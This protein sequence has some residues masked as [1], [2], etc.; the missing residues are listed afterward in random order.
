MD[1]HSD[2]ATTPVNNIISKICVACVEDVKQLQNWYESQTKTLQDDVRRKNEQLESAQVEYTAIIDQLKKKHAELEARIVGSKNEVPADSERMDANRIEEPNE[3]QSELVEIKMEVEDYCFDNDNVNDEILK[4]EFEICEFEDGASSVADDGCSGTTSLDQYDDDDETHQFAPSKN[5]PKKRFICQIAG[6]EKEYKTESSLTFHKQRVHSVGG[7]KYPCNEPG[8]GKPFFSPSGL[9]RH[10]RHHTGE[11]PFKCLKCNYAS[12]DKTL[13]RKHLLTHLTEQE[14]DGVAI[15]MGSLGGTIVM[16]EVSTTSTNTDQTNDEAIQ[17]EMRQSEIGLIEGAD[18]GATT[19]AD[20]PHKCQVDGC[21]KAYSTKDGLALHVKRI[22]VNWRPHICEYRNCTKSFT[23]RSALTRHMQMHLDVK[24]YQCTHCVRSFIERWH[25]ERH[26][27][28]HVTSEIFVCSAAQCEQSFPNL[29][30][31]KEH[32]R[33]EHPA[34]TTLAYKLGNNDT[35]TD[36][37]ADLR[38]TVNSLFYLNRSEP[39]KCEQP[40]CSQVFVMKTDFMIHLR[41]AHPDHK[42]YACKEPGCTKAYRLIRSLYTHQ[43]VHMERSHLCSICGK[44]FSRPSSLNSHMT[45]HDTVRRFVCAVAD[46]GKAFRSNAKRS[47]HMITHSEERPFACG[48]A[49][50]DKAFKLKVTAVEHRRIHTKEKPYVC[51]EQACGRAFSTSSFLSYHTRTV[52]RHQRS[53]VCDYSQCGKA[54]KS[55]GVL[56]AHLKYH[57]RS[58]K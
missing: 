56:K 35:T 25:M 54:F 29:K 40:D 28:T 12:K 6:C 7:A 24:P 1:N 42:P 46:C 52:H 32:T 2:A 37:V 8:C 14:S 34:E 11:R 17:P 45:T 18:A 13:L 22:H 23:Y 51:K 26:M 27:I 30:S 58:G 9:A 48:F 5:Q 55:T 15:D 36:T 43:K 3:P 47:H 44:S 41:D 31:L 50:C 10:Q 53:Y 4:S 16:D 39:Y 21:Y 20:Q 49:G 38:D 19:V 57:E 33:E